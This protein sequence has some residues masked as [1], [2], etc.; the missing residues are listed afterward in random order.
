LA[1]VRGV[2]LHERATARTERLGGNRPSD[3]EK[4]R[5]DLNRPNSCEMSEWLLKTLQNSGD[6]QFEYSASLPNYWPSL[7][8][9]L[10]LEPE[11]PRRLIRRRLAAALR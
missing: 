3:K 2:V 4:F 7:S 5:S 11:T 6:F 8:S 9:S 10:H 1:P